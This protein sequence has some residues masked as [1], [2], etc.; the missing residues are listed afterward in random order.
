[1]GGAN[2]TTPWTPEERGRKILQKVRT[3]QSTWR[4]IPQDCTHQQR[5]ENL[6]SKMQLVSI[7]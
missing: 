5:R 1:M 4:H 2:S 3:Y 7:L 6:K